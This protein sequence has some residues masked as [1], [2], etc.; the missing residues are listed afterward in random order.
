MPTWDELFRQEEHRLQDPHQT[1]VAF[2]EVLRERRAETVLDLGCGAGRHVVYLTH[3]GFRVIGADNSPTGL[4]VT[5]HRL[6][7]RNLLADLHLCDITAI[8]LADSSMDAVITLYVIYHN[9]LEGIQRTVGEIGRVLRPG[10]LL[11]VSLMS[12]RGYRYGQ[13]EEVE[14]DTFLPTIGPDAGL[15]HHFFDAGGVRSLMESFHVSRLFLDEHEEQLDDGRTLLHSH[16]VCVAE[17]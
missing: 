12:Q 16:W 5:R 9:C 6:A 17:K 15:P 13:G 10:G 7:G 14:Q 1:V 3:L 8:P 4:S 11:L 2:V